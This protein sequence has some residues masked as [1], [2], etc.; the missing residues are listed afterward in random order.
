MDLNGGEDFELFEE[1]V[2]FLVGFDGLDLFES[3]FVFDHLE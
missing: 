1:G 2:D 3:E